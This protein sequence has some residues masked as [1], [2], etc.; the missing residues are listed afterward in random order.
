LSDALQIMLG[1]SV[2]VASPEGYELPSH[3][4]EEAATVAKHGARLRL[5][6]ARLREF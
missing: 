1:V 4:V 3:V 5:F 2:H 6:R